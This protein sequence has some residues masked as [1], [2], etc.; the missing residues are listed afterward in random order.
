[1]K[2][3]RDKKVLVFNRLAS[4]SGKGQ[5]ALPFPDWGKKENR[6]PKGEN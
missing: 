5:G 4:L 6:F 1:M 2:S 3:R